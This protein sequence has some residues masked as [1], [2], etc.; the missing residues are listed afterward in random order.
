MKII[1]L[2]MLVLLTARVHADTNEALS[3][4]FEFDVRDTTGTT[5]AVSGVLSVDAREMILM[6]LGYKR[7]G[8]A[9]ATAKTMPRNWPQAPSQRLRSRDSPQ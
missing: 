7:C 4:V 1:L 8:I 3:D 6:T 9:T 2:A 5:E